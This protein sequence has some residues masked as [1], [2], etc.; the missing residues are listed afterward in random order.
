MQSE[1]TYSNHD[2]LSANN[3]IYQEIYQSQKEGAML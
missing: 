1:S 2:T 3:Q